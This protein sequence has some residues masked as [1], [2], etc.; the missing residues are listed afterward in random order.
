MGWCFHH[1][2]LLGRQRYSLIAGSDRQSRILG[3]APRLLPSPRGA[4]PHPAFH[5]DNAIIPPRLDN[6]PVLTSCPHDVP[7]DVAVK[8]ESVRGDSRDTIGEAI[9]TYGPGNDFL[10][11]EHSLLAQRRLFLAFGPVRQQ[12]W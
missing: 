12:T 11:C 9:S 7:D 10:H 2:F 6:L 1:Q 8:L 5:S 3:V 4:D